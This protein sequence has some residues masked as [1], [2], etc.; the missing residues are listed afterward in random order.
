VQHGEQ[1]IVDKLIND[2]DVGDGRAAAHEQ[3]DIGVSKDTL[4][5]NLVLNFRQKLI[6]DIGVKDFL[7]SN[8]SA[9]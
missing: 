9:V 3:A 1:T 5:D 4:H 7:D 8:W 2:Y 6:C